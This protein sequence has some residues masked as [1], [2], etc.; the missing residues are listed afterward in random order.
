MH[1]QWAMT[2]EWDALMIVGVTAMRD[3]YRAR[4]AAERL[5]ETRE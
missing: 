1:E 5:V 3:I 4:A 2:I